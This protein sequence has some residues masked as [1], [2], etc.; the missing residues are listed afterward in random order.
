MLPIFADHLRF[1]DLVC[2]PELRISTLAQGDGLEDMVSEIDVLGE[3]RLVV[4]AV[5]AHLDLRFVL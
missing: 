4:G 1:V 5:E 2:A 3:L